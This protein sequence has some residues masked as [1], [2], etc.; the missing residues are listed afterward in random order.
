MFQKILIANRGEIA[1]RILQ[2]ARRLGIST[3]A[4]YSSA[5]RDSMHVQMAD[6]AI[7]IGAA[8]P[9]ESYLNI[10]RIIQAVQQTG[11]DAVHPGYGFLSENHVLAGRCEADGV[12]FVGPRSEAIRI[13]A[14][15]STAGDIA[16][17]AQ[18]P[19]LPGY[20]GSNQ[21]GGDLIEAAME[22]GFPVLLK[23]ALGGGG[24]GMR[25]VD[26]ESHL[27]AN[28]VVAKS[29]SLE[30]FGSDEIVVEKYLESARHIEVQVAADRH[31][32]CLHLHDRD[33]SS[34]RRFQKIVEEAPAIDIK[35]NV[36]ARM[37]ESAV[38]IARTLGYDNLGTM[39]F[40]LQNDEFYFMEMNTRLQ[41]EHPVTER[42]TDT[43]LVE[44][45]IRI[46]AGESLQSFGYR[47]AIAGHSI[48][49][50]IY[51][52]NPAK[53]FLPS[54]GTLTY[55]KLPDSSDAVDVHS[56]VRQGDTISEHYDPMIAKLVA[57]G[58]TREEALA[59]MIDAL[60]ETI[61]A[62]VDVNVGMLISL[63]RHDEF[64]NGAVDV[65]FVERNLSDL[66]RSESQPP[67][68]AIALAVLWLHAAR[69]NGGTKNSTEHSLDPYSPWQDG[70]GWRMHAR[71]EF[72]YRISC[73]GKTHA[74]RYG[75]DSRGTVQVD[76]DS[77]SIE[78]ELGNIDNTTVA[79]M[80]N[81]KSRAMTLIR[82]QD[83]L[84]I[85]DGGSRYE[86]RI[87]GRP[88]SAHMADENSGN[89]AAPLPGRVARI[90]V[91]VGDSVSNGDCLLVIDA[92]KMEHR[93]C[94]TFD[95]I[96]AAIRYAVDDQVDEGA[97]CVE[98]DAHELQ[99]NQHD[100]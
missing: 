87:A 62:G 12:T 8:R 100:D 38:R 9:S 17:K 59:R 99:S 64:R 3:V 85:F 21:D 41:V 80:L 88:E 58:P 56:G 72:V 98:V 29:E 43:D 53:N 95:G 46:A 28:L 83:R 51:A 45:Q 81:G 30:A 26:S 32:D 16:T 78:C 68:E 27:E 6:E 55:L 20:R 92:M 13:M 50:R 44:W 77:Q 73:A 18:V 22:I 84:T 96:V 7:E 74:I 67:A 48:E 71:R 91:S 10:D 25:I 4:V 19:V 11:A 63:L 33:C 54:P 14:S 94:A 97:T 37:H 89:L 31:G 42:I 60:S 35:P 24:R 82:I 61:I 57:T 86:L 75:E 70:T 1:C 15:K 40:L 79:A 34:Q 90:N 76:W 66:A 49:T 2:T 69:K 39:E 47:D 65:N 5:D 23:S 52:E 93:L 36:R